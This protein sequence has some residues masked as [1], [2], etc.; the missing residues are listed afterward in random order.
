MLTKMN[1]QKS[2]AY[3]EWR[4]LVDESKNTLTP[5]VSQG[6]VAQEGCKRLEA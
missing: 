5:Q 2:P 3:V 6:Q 1:F 4:R